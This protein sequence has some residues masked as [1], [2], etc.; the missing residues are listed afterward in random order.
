MPKM[1]AADALLA[2]LLPKAEPGFPHYIF[3][4][5]KE[6]REVSCRATADVLDFYAELIN[7]HGTRGAPFYL[8]QLVENHGGNVADVAAGGIFFERLRYREDTEP[9]FEKCVM[10]LAMGMCYQGNRV[11]KMPLDDFDFPSTTLPTLFVPKQLTVYKFGDHENLDQTNLARPH[12]KTPRDMI[13]L[14][15]FCANVEESLTV[16]FHE[17]AAANA[18]QRIQLAH[19]ETLVLAGRAIREFRI[20]VRACKRA[21]PVYLFKLVPNLMAD[22]K[23]KRDER[24]NDE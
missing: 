12:M 22:G 9:Y 18:T 7:A 20:S 3:R 23:R 6:T 14:H 5:D 17:R 2:A 15:A 24:G 1:D 21:T 16:C 8:E 19:M 11:I 10:S 13:V 4:T